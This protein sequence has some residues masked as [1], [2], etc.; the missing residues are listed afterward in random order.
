VP[1]V[2]TPTV[3]VGWL[4]VVLLVVA[5]LLACGGRAGAL[6]PGHGRVVHLVDGDTLDVVVGGTTERVRLLGIDTPETVAPDRPVECFGRE[7]SARLAELLPEGTVVALERDVEARDRYGRL[8]AY[9]TRAAD[10]LFVNA[11][12]AR[13]GYAE[14]LTIAPNR[15]RAGELGA[16]VAEAR[17]AGRGRWGACPLPA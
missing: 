2:R 15:A 6:P 8:L 4:V 10:G 17:R 11:E 5:G 16:A 7:A 1:L 14:L 13:G 12:L 9:V 3:R